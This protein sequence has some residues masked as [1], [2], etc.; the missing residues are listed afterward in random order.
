MKNILIYVALPILIVVL[1]YF[2]VTG[3]QKPVKFEQEQR[4]REA[5]SIVRLKDIRTLQVAYKAE[6]GQ[7][8]GSFDTLLNFYNT[9]Q[10]K[11]VKQIGSEDDSVAVAQ[12]RV[13][14]DTAWVFIRDTLLRRSDFNI[15]SLPFVPG[16]SDRFE[17]RARIAR[18][19]G[20]NVPL[21]EACVPFDV[22]LRGMDRQLLI[23]L[24][25]DRKKSN[26]YHG[27]KVGSVET[28]NNNAGNWE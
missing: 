1:G 14:R 11:V 25:D 7:Y 17:M 10:L 22:L 20:V 27:L 15:D 16:T 6:H 21:F 13:F 24:N 28:P 26:K 12:K 18:V 3:I 19:S 2:L 23:N 8:T 4:K 9:G 5:K